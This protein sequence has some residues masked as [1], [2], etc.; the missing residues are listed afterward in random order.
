MTDGH[1]DASATGGPDADTAAA[2]FDVL[3]DPSRVA[4]LR[5]LTNRTHARSESSVAFADLRRAVGVDDAG[6]FNYHL[7]KLRDRFVV[8]RDG[9]YA[10]T[11]AGMKAIGSVEAGTYT[12]DPD[13]RE[14]TIEHPCPECG[15]P[16]YATYE[17]HLVTI[18]C[19][20]HDVMLQ[21]AVPPS[22]ASDS[23]I[24]EIVEFAHRDI[25][26]DLVRAANGTC[27]VCAG[28]M[29]ADSFERTD[30]GRL[31]VD[32][33]CQNCWMTIKTPV[34]LVAFSHPAV[35]SLYYDNGIDVHDVFPVNLDFAE[36]T[37]NAEF[38][39]EDPVEVEVV[40]EVEDDA[41]TLAIDGDLNVTEQ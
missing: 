24:S 6:R 10:P 12:A 23:T 38:V 13:P 3:S 9:G 28:T 5:E 15:E 11:Y 17:N 35:V 2:A 27:P 20:D 1:S 32:I 31:V 40:V 19:G 4:I 36:S 14:G 22:T 26:R 8:K 16:M 18:E 37:G 25:R 7:G 34:G 41:T 39:S 30:P 29:A 33:D 21:T